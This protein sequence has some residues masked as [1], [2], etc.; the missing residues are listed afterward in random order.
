MIGSLMSMG[1]Y[2]F[3]LFVI[4]VWMCVRIWRRSPLLAIGAF[5]FWPLS[6]VAL[7]MCWGDKDS[8]IR[9]PFVLSAV[10]TLLIGVMATRAVDKGVDEM[11][12][13]LTDEDIAEI[14]IGDPALAARLEAA[15]ERTRAEYEE[16]EYDDDGAEAGSPRRAHAAAADPEAVPMPAPREYSAV[17]VEAQQRAELAMAVQAVSWR[18]G[19]LDLTPA[20][21][22][23][24]LPRDFRFVPRKQVSRVARARGTPLTDEVLGWVVHRQVD[25]AREDAWYVQLRYVPT[26]TRLSAPLS[27]GDKAADAPAQARFAERVA[28]QLRAGV[29]PQAPSWDASHRFASWQWPVEG[30]GGSYGEHVAAIPLRGGVLEFSVPRLHETHAE[31]GARS[32]RLMALRTT[33]TPR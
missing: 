24:H 7:V 15:R 11:A 8:D 27:V 22:S 32:A 30:T 12:W 2:L 17:E 6:I 19:V 4:S 5:L 26:S 23:L 1:G 29:P 33:P 10:V 13:A 16:S 20:A 3:V 28:S 14:R 9:V 31:L 25:L 21:A 18:F